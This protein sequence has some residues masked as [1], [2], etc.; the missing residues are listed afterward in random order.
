MA[1]ASLQCSRGTATAFLVARLSLAP[2]ERH[3]D[4]R[5]RRVLVQEGGGTDN[6]IAKRAGGLFGDA[7]DLGGKAADPEVD[8]L[9]FVD[10][11]E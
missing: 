10:S 11:E 6:A 3:G 5:G 8:V 1:S 2:S 4:V 7:E 9:G